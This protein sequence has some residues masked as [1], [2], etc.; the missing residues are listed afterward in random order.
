MTL[1][2]HWWRCT[3]DTERSSSCLQ[4]L[5]CTQQARGWSRCWPA[6]LQKTQQAGGPLDPEAL[7][8]RLLQAGRAAGAKLVAVHP[9]GYLAQAGEVLEQSL[10]LAPGVVLLG[11][12]Q[13]QLVLPPLCLSLSLHHKA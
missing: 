12:E 10:L 9:S 2:M 3:C 8:R 11:L 5:A 7:H 4:E 1:L 6:L 13:Q